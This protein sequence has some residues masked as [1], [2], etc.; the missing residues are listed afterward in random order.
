LHPIICGGAST[1]TGN[2]FTAGTTPRSIT[3]DP[4]GKF[5]YVANNGSGSVS[6]YSIVDATGQLTA[7][8]TY[9]TESY[10]Y[11]IRIDRSGSY[12]Y[13]THYSTTATNIWTFSI[14]SNGTLSVVGQSAAG[15]S[16]ASIAT[17]P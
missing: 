14:N 2:N 8:G 12:A 9:F 13:V 5:V 11:A 17:S 1:C 16:P 15:N 10:P 7:V 4:S 3:I 6:A